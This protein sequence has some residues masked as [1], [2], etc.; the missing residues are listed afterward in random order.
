MS[1]ARIEN[2]RWIVGSLLS[3]RPELAG[4]EPRDTL[5]GLQT[6]MRGLL[7]ARGPAPVSAELLRRQDEELRQQTADKGVVRPQDIGPT[8]S[9][10]RLLLWQ[11][12]ITRLAVDAIVNAANEA[13][14]GCFNPLHGC[15]DNAIHSAAGVELRLECARLMEAQGH[16]EPAGS[17]KMTAGY[18]LPARHVLHTVGPIVRGGVPTPLQES[19]LGGCYRSCLAAA[20]AAGLESVAFCCV[21]TGVYGFPQRLAAEI[22]VRTVRQYLDTTAGTH[23]KTVIFNVFKDEDLEIYRGLL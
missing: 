16:A 13:M 22:A 7:N 18:N 10:S 9:D 23:I 17:A 6:A 8:G 5:S 11:G 3:E 2:L 15:I 21:S 14:L 12:D 19:E 1:S 20:D 4:A